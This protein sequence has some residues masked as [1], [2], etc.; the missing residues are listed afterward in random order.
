[1][2]PAT[3]AITATLTL[4]FLLLGVKET[5][6]SRYSEKLCALCLAVSMTWAGL[7]IAY[8]IGVFHDTALLGLLMGSTVLG[9]FYTVEDRLDG[10]VELFRLPVYLTLLTGAYI[11]MTA[12]VD[13]ALFTAI[14]LLWTGFG[15]LYLY[16]EDERVHEH[17]RR[18]IDCCKDW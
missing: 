1:M 16:R 10:A 9:I 8:W 11:L 4:F 5:L 13:A 17:V 12:T 3:T 15:L 18:I 14:A 2:D 7:L 6:D